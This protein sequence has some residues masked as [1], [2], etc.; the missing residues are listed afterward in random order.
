[1]ESFE[2][3]VPLTSKYKCSDVYKNSFGWH[4]YLIRNRTIMISY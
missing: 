1:M 2:M 3:H 4:Q